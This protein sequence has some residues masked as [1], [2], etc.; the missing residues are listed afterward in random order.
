MNTPPPPTPAGPPQTV[1]TPP[2]A[3][4][5]DAG[6]LAPVSSAPA[7]VT[8]AP[9]A[10]QSKNVFGDEPIEWLG[11]ALIGLAIVS[12]VAKLFVM[13]KQ[14][15]QMES[16]DKKINTVLN[17]VKFNL[18]KQMGNKYESLS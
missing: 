9:A 2:A 6:A 13:R 1:L 17:E 7:P 11:I 3:P 14:L 16:D 8:P 18:K 15:R 12:M 10:P 5:P 4:I